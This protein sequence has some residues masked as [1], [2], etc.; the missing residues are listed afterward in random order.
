MTEKLHPA[1]NPDTPVFVRSCS[2]Y[3]KERMTAAVADAMAALGITRESL[4][5][6]RIA[7]KPNLVMK[8]PAEAAATVHPALADALLTFL[9]SCD[10]ADVV[11]AESPGGAYTEAAL[12]ASY[13][14][15]GLEA[16]IAG[17]KVRLNYDVSSVTVSYPDGKQCKQFEIITPIAEADVIFS[18]SKLKS[19][20]L[21]RMSGAIKNTFGT[22]P[23]LTKFEYH[24][25]FRDY[26]EFNAMLV[27]LS[28]WLHTKGKMMVDLQDAVIGMEGNGPTGGKPR[29]I[30]A[31]LCSEN[32]FC[33]DRVAEAI[34]G[35][36]GEVPMVED[37]C[38]R[39][40]C[41]KTADEVTVLGDDW[42]TLVIP[43]FAAP[44]SAYGIKNAFLFQGAFPRLFEPRPVIRKKTCVGCGECERSCPVHT[45]TL[46]ECSDGKRRAEIHREN[47]IRCFCCQ[48]LC[49]IHSVDIHK[50]PF[51]SLLASFRH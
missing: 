28:L 11:I 40:L 9:D 41:P 26:T 43:D 27:D 13:R 25:R 14:T 3:D 30:G 31:F 2:D 35:C 39:G 12:R 16:A 5:G 51:L 1:K 4:S 19:H 49:P 21:T 33:L 17:H 10:T 7:I 20:S 15:C 48:E 46:K 38:T 24:A 18:L 45:I 50:N 8:K 29:K 36:P 32:P 44:D 34:I 42:R 6:K 22:I 23:G 37:A 47:C